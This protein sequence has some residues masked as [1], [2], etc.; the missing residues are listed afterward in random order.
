MTV[1]YK[2]AMMRTL[3]YDP[4]MDLVAVAPGGMLVAYC[5]CFINVEENTLTGHKHGY[6]DPV[7]THPDFQRRGLSRSLMLTGLALL[8]DRGM[9]TACLGTDS[10]NIAML[11]SA[12]SVGFRITKNV[13]W[14]GK[15]IHSA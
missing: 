12:G 11:G 13:F 10:Q 9:D 5:V 8:K 3:Y 6:T 7:A 4:E 14:Y 2:L 1:E 15:P